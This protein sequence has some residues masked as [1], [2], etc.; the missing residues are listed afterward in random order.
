MPYSDQLSFL[1]DSL[2]YSKRLDLSSLGRIADELLFSDEAEL[3][4]KLLVSEASFTTLLRNAIVH[5]RCQVEILQ[6]DVDYVIAR[7][8]GRFGKKPQ[9][10]I[11][12]RFTACRHPRFPLVWVVVTDAGAEFLAKPF[13]H[14]LKGLRPR[15]IAPILRTPQLRQLMEAIEARLMEVPLRITQVGSRSRIR[16]E[17]AQKTVER[18]RRW[19]DLTVEEA[20]S[21]VLDSGQWV[22]DV[23]SSYPGRRVDR[24]V[25]V[26]INR[27][28]VMSFERAASVAIDVMLDAVAE[29][30]SDWFHFLRN[31][32]RRPETQYHSRPFRINFNYPALES[33][34]Q[35][36]LLANALTS[37]PSV[38]CTTLHGNPYYHAVMLDYADG[39]TYEVLVSDDSAITVFPQGRSTV[40]AL[41]RLCSRVFS[42]FR[43]GELVEV[44]NAS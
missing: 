38:S 42:E 32:E 20:F 35:I 26:R 1:V 4:V 10:V 7:V 36:K 40:A 34:Q 25:H 23:A 6:S 16:S 5:S 28:S 14:L 30:A 19:T 44:A 11:D 31:R 24:P 18:D 41:Q 9:T 22:T 39:S 3:R 17:R 12:G 15:P 27:Y 37:M 43:E 13:R 8:S 33:R 2:L 21:D 29:M